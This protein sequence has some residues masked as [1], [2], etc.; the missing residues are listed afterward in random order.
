MRSLYTQK[1]AQSTSRDCYLDVSK[2]SGKTPKMDGENNEKP[3]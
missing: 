1:K 3:Y 2:N